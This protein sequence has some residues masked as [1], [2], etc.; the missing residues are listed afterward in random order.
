MNC[1]KV[2]G[3][4]RENSVKIPASM[5][6]AALFCVVLRADILLSADILLIFLRNLQNIS[7]Y[8][9]LN[10]R[11]RCIYQ[12]PPKDDAGLAPTFYELLPP[13]TYVFTLFSRLKNEY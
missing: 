6:L 11:I 9:M 2:R 7:A 5:Q 8:Y 10:H 13:I 3:D 12:S 4:D 1:S